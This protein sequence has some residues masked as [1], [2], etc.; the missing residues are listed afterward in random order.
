[1]TPRISCACP[2]A[3]LWLGVSVLDSVGARWPCVVPDKTRARVLCWDCEK[4]IWCCDGRQRSDMGGIHR[5][6]H[7]L[8]WRL[9]PTRPGSVLSTQF[10][11][12][13]SRI[14]EV[15]NLVFQFFFP[16]I[17]VVAWPGWRAVFPGQF[18]T[19]E[20]SG[21]VSWNCACC[22]RAPATPAHTVC[23]RARTSAVRLGICPPRTL[24]R[25]A[26]RSGTAG[27]AV[28]RVVAAV[29]G[30]LPAWRSSQ[31]LDLFASP[32]AGVVRRELGT[33]GRALAELFRHAGGRRAVQ[34]RPWSWRTVRTIG[35]PSLLPPS[36]GLP[37][38]S[39]CN[40]CAARSTL[41]ETNAQ[42]PCRKTDPG[43][44]KP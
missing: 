9:T 7:A 30:V 20:I 11:H 43:W 14:P 25:A 6:F 42:P 33:L 3:H 27:A 44:T 38:P 34:S 21:L 22:T 10:V 41:H 8:A 32:C 18:A 36:S 24:N 26:C 29:L 40:D 17:S 12:H 23:R 16:E 2:S 28:S 13:L 19:H 5:T 15:C 39:I 31:V 37:P 1:M 35:R 4:Q